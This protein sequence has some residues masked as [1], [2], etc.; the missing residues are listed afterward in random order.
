MTTSKKKRMSMLDGLAAGGA[1]SPVAT[2][3]MISSNR[4]LR[5]ARDAVDAHHVW[6]L[7]PDAIMDDRLADRLNPD[8]VLD[9]RESIEANGQAV[10]IL[11]RRHPQDPARYLLVYGRR[12]L[13]AIRLSDKVDKVRALV[14]NLDDG[15]ALRAQI[16][17][18]MARRDLTYIEKAIFSQSLIDSGFGNQSQVAEV[19]TVTKSAIS[20]ALSVVE[21]VGPDL[22][23]MI[24]AAPGIGR[25]K[26]EALGRQIAEFGLDRG[27]LSRV[28]EDVHTRAT[29]EA[30]VE[31]AQS[32]TSEV[33][34]RAF[35]AVMKAAAKAHRRSPSPSL[36]KAHPLM[37]SGRR[38]GK[39]Q[40]T[41]KGLVISLDEGPFARWVED[42]AQALIE[43]LHARW[44]SCAED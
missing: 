18:N 36:S 40:R 17:E 13:E 32:E 7:D 33:S 5:S 25:P 1:P 3:S 8:D 22:I 20:M 34:V 16:S 27:E 10:P 2:G 24:G 26:W 23:R 4:A 43:E 30:V 41:A 29:G 9:L 37:I 21:L 6:E 35:E 38:G 44:S 42:E 39:V 14:A 15:S 28:A 19:L 12:R 11:V 31:G